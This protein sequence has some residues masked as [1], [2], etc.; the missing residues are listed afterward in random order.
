MKESFNKLNSSVIFYESTFFLW[1]K[2]KPKVCP[3]TVSELYTNMFNLYS[4]FHLLSSLS[5]TSS[6]TRFEAGGWAAAPSCE[7]IVWFFSSNVLGHYVAVGRSPE[8]PICLPL[9]LVFFSLSWQR[10]RAKYGPNDASEAG[11]TQ[12]NT[13]YTQRVCE[14]TQVYAAVGIVCIN[15]PDFITPVHLCICFFVSLQV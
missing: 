12:S 13:L 7:A 10:Y 1:R 3:R 9:L 15:S 4:S 2:W 14:S 6:T 11:G 8:Q 5:R